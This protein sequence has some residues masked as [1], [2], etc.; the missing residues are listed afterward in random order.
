MSDQ[1]REYFERAAFSFDRLYS[2]DEMGTA[3]RWVNHHFRRDIYERFLLTMELARRQAVSSALDVGCGSGRYEIGLA[4]LGLKRVMGIDLSEPMINLTKRA[5]KGKADFEFACGDFMA[6]PIG[7]QFDLVFAMGVFD[8]IARPGQ[9]L[10]KMREAS[11]SYVM[12]SFPSI[13]FYRTP[14]RKGRYRIKRCP[15]YFYRRDDIARLSE[16]TGFDR[17][18]VK[19]IQGAGMDYVATFFK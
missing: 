10:Q 17:V 11:S 14:I 2:E 19:K 1:V 16:A 8:Y 15:V 3:E 4:D 18:E 6:Q 5:L 9:F 7:E 12:A 13:S